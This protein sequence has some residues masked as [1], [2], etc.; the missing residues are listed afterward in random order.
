MEFLGLA[1][2]VLGSGAAATVTE[3]RLGISHQLLLPVLDLIGVNVKV[4]GE[5]GQGSVPSHGCHRYLRLEARRMIAS[6]PLGHLLL[7]FLDG[8][9]VQKIPLSRVDQLSN[10]WGPPLDTH[11]HMHVAVAIDSRGI[12]LGA[13]SF[14]ADSEG[15]RALLTWAE[16]YGGIE[17][18]GIEGTGGYGVGLSR[19]VH[20]AGH[21]VVEVNRVD[22]R[23]R[24][25]AG[26][27]DTIDA[28]AAAR[29]VLAGQ[30]TATPKTAD[31]AVEMMRQ[32]KV[33][34][35][36]A[37]KARTTA[38]STL[39]QILVNAPPVL[40]EPLQALTDRALVTRCAGLRPGPLDTP[41]ASGKHTLRS[42]A[43]RWLTLADEIT[44]HDL[45]LARLTAETSPT[46]REGFAVGANTAAAMFI[47][48]G[49]NPE[50]I[51]SEAAFAKLCGACPVPASSG[52]TTGRHRLYRGG[53]RQ[54]NAALHRAVVV[55]MRYH[56]P[57]IDYVIR[58]RADGRTKRDIIRCLKR[59]LAR[60]IYQR[61]M[62]DFRTRQQLSEA[63]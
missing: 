36:S 32:L 50:R 62:R 2:R 4:L 37:V 1:L 31:G 3:E 34:R 40:R 61:V 7:L 56:Q 13:H 11:K 6:F 20:R 19:T 29:A 47:I 60:E 43:R 44:T 27:S 41:V 54:A 10:R 58:R 16:A 18:V 46:L 23:L 63:S 9:V 39:K 8:N 53:H 30:A 22:R 33:A 48:F 15:Y 38:M 35:E 12:R 55:R 52:M 57:T 59:F 28:E 24:R 51:R 25:A 45:H 14:G 5:L 42:L 21:R 49:D 17:A 26:K